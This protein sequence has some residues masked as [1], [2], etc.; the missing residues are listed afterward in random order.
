MNPPERDDLMES[1][2]QGPSTPPRSARHVAQGGPDVALTAGSAAVGKGR[3]S[4]RRKGLDD[5]LGRYSA[6]YIYLSFSLNTIQASSHCVATLG[7]FVIPCWTN[8]I[9]AVYGRFEGILARDPRK[10]AQRGREGAPIS[11]RCRTKDLFLLF[12]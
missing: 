12:P 1:Q 2:V 6:V 9:A 5:T 10:S 11:Y 7:M 4:G 8:L 3:R